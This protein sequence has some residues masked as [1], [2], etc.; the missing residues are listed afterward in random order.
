MNT[1]ELHIRQ[2]IQ[3][4]A[5]ASASVLVPE[6]QLDNVPHSRKRVI[7][8]NNQVNVHPAVQQFLSFHHVYFSRIVD[9]D[10]NWSIQVSHHVITNSLTGYSSCNERWWMNERYNSD[11]S[12]WEIDL[13]GWTTDLKTKRLS[14]TVSYFDPA[15]LVAAIFP[16]LVR[17]VP[18]IADLPHPLWVTARVRW[19]KV[20]LLWGMVVWNLSS[21]W[22]MHLFLASNVQ[23]QKILVP[24]KSESLP[25]REYSNDCESIFLRAFQWRIKFA[26]CFG[27][28]IA[29]CRGC[30]LPLCM[31]WLATKQSSY[32]ADIPFEDRNSLHARLLGLHTI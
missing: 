11:R 9:I 25:L 28:D 14:E 30:G 16:Q 13:N 8:G 20:W 2:E 24:V 22:C 4:S 6:L 32:F 10:M 21:E 26:V 31:K 3:A 7:D 15:P 18:R 27:R 29:E 19:E 17:D 1:R 23:R 12:H 5:S